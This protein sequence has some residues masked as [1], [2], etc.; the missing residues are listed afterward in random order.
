MLLY[1][2]E[3]ADPYANIHYVT[4]NENVSNKF[5]EGKLKALLSTSCDLFKE[6]FFLIDTRQL[7]VTVR[8]MPS[9]LKEEDERPPGVS[10][11]DVRGNVFADVQAGLAA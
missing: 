6:I 11:E 5:N 3:R 7:V 10:L 4:D 8:W 2:I 1:L 9:H